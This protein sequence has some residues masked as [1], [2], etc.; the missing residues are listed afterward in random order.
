MKTKKPKKMSQE[1]KVQKEKTST[2]LK[3]EKTKC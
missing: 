3:E 1:T 2:M